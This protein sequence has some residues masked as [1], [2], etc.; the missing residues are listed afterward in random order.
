MMPLF[1][2]NLLSFGNQTLDHTPNLLPADAGGVLSFGIQPFSPSA[3]GSAPNNFFF[4]LI[5]SIEEFDAQVFPNVNYLPNTSAV[6]NPIGGQDPLTGIDLREMRSAGNLLLGKPADVPAVRE[7][8]FVD[9]AVE[10]YQSLVAGIQPGA[11][12]VIL[13]AN[14]NGTDQI[15][16][17]LAHRADISALHI[18]SHGEPGSLRLGNST[19]NLAGIAETQ[20]WANALNPDA[21]IL[22][23]G[24]DVASGTQ[25][26]AF[27]EKLGELTGADVAAS[28]DKT[29]SAIEGGDWLLEYGAGSI[30]TDLAFNEPA[31][32]AYDSVFAIIDSI[33]QSTFAADATF[34]GTL[35]GGLS[36][37][38]Y[39][40]A[41]NQYY[42]IADARNN[43]TGPVRFYTFN[44]NVSS[45]TLAAGGATATG[46]TLLGNPTAFA[47][48]TSDTEGIALAPGG[49]TA[50]IASEGVFSGTT[51]TAQPFINQFNIATGVQTSALPVPSKFTATA[52]TSGIVS[53]AAFESLSISPTG[54]FLF[55]ATEN[56]LKQ[57]GAVPT[58]S[59]GTPSRILTYN[60]GTSTAGAEYLYNTDA[61]NGISEILALDN[62][63][64]LVL[65]RSMNPAAQT[66]SLRLY[67]VSLTGAT[68]ISG[69]NALTGSPTAAQKTLVADFQTTAGFP[70]N[71]FEGMTLGPTLPSGKRSLI[72]ISDNNYGAGFLQL[73]TQVAAFSVNSA[74]VLDN[75]GNPT[76]TTI[77]EDPI[78][79]TGT[80]VST[81]IGSSITDLDSADPEGIAVTGLDTTNGIWQYSTDGTTWT[82]LGTPSESAAMLLTAD[83]NTRIRFSPN[84]NYNGVAGNITFRAWDGT[85]GTNGTTAN[86]TTLG[87]GGL[88]SF[89]TATETASITV[90]AVN[91]APVLTVPGAQTINQ[92]TNSAIAGISLSDID[93]GTGNLQ[94]TLS[95]T[96]GTLTFGT[97]TSLTFSTG[98][99][100]AD[101]SMTFTGSLTNI[102]SALANLTYQGNA[103]Y[104]GID[105]INL[106]V[107]DLG[108]TGTGGALTA[109]NSIA[110]N[111]TA[112]PY[113]AGSVLINE[114]V[115]DPQRDWSS[116]NFNG[117]V[118]A[119]AI[120][121]GTDEWVELYIRQAGLDLTNWT[122]ELLDGTNVFGSLSNNG[123]FQFSNYISAGGGSFTN[124][125]AGD[126]LVLGDVIGTGAMNDNITLVIKDHTGT[127]IDQVIVG[128][129]GAPS[130]VATGVTNEAVARVPNGNDAIDFRKQAATLGT[131][132]NIGQLALAEH[133][134]AQVSDQFAAPTSLVPAGT[135]LHRFR[136][137]ATNEPINISNL[138]FT[139]SQT[140][141]ANTDF[142]GLRLVQDANNN[143]VDDAGD[144][145]VGTVESPVNI[146]DGLTFSNITAPVGTSNYLLSTGVNNLLAGDRLTFN[147]TTANI[148]AAGN[149]SLLPL[150]TTGTVSGTVH[151]VDVPPL[152]VVINE[153][154]WM[155]TQAAATDEWIELY[156][157][158]NNAIDL[159]GWTLQ[160][161]GGGTLNYTIQN[162]VIAAGGY[163]L[164]ER[165]ANTTVSN[166]AA[167]AIFTGGINNT[168][169]ISLVL[170]ES[171]GNTIDTANGNGGAWPAGSNTAATVRFTMERI[172]PTSADIDG[173]WLTNTGLIQNGLDAGNNAIHGTPRAQNSVYAI[174]EVV[175][176]ES[177]GNTNIAEGGVTDTYTVVLKTPVTAPVTINLGTA[178]GQTSVSNPFLTFDINNWNI[179]QTVTVSAVD[180]TTLEGN[181][182]GTINHVASSS[183]SRYNG[184]TIASVNAN[185]TDNESTPP[186][187]NF[188][189]G[190]LNYTENSGSVLVDAGATVT[191]P[192]SPDFNGG[193]LTVQFASATGLAEDSLS[194][195]NQGTGAGQISIVGNVVSYGGVAIAT[196]SGGTNG[197]TP[198]VINFNSN[199]NITS[200][201]ALLQNITYQNSSE[202]PSTASRTLQFQMT[203]GD[204]G[205]GLP[206]NKAINLTAVN[207]AP[208]ISAIAPQTTNEDTTT[209]PITFT[210]GDIET[211]A[212]A[213][214][215]T[216]ISSN[217]TLIPDANIAFGGS[218]NNRT[219]T[220]TPA[221]NQN[222]NATITINVN[223]GIAINSTSFNLTV[224]AVNDA[225]V[226]A[227]N[228]GL[229]LTEGTSG[230]INTGT[231]QV[232]DSDTAPAQLIYTVSNSPTNGTLFLNNV[233]TTSFTQDDISNNRIT[234]L[235]S[236]N[237]TASDSFTFTVSDGTNTVG[238]STFNLTINAVNDAPVL[239]TN[240]GLTLTEGSSTTLS[241]G[242]LQVTDV[243]TAPAQL[244][245]SVTNSPTNGTL[246][247]NNVATTSFTQDDINN[248]RITYL[249]SG[250]ETS[251]DSFIFTVSDGT[252]TLGASTFNFVINAVNDAPVLATNAGLTL[253]EGTS[254]VINTGTLQVTD[255]DTA[256]AQLIYTVTNSPTNGSLFLN[257]VATTSFTQDDIDNN[258]ITYL[259][260]GNETASD[261]FTFTVSDGTNTVGASTFNLT[262]NAVNDAPVL[263]TNAGLTLTEGGSANVSSG[264][265]QVTDVDTAPAQLI[266]SVTNSPINGTL[267]LNNVATTSFTQD[268]INNNRVTYLHSGS[269]TSTDSFIFT[270]SDGTN[271]V[272]A[273]TFNFVINAVNDVP[274]LATNAGLTLN[275]GTSGIINTGTLQVTDSDT[276]PAQ[277][278]YSVT[279]SPTNGTLF[280]NNV[281]TTSFTQDDIN[282]NRITYLH[283][284]NET[285]SDSFTF[286][287]SDGT[288]TLSAS[289]FNFTINA[290][291]DV[292][293][294]STN[295]GLTLNEGTSANVSSGVLQVTDVDTAPAQLIYSVTNS[296]TNGTL[297]LNGVATTSFTQDDINN[298]RVTYLH[299]GS[300]TTTDSFTFTVSDGANTLNAATF[301]INITPVNDTPAA[302]NDS[303]IAT[304]DTPLTVTLANSVLTN[305]TDAENNSLTAPLVTNPNNGTVVFNANGTFT[306]TPNANFAGTDSF[307]YQASDGTA[308]SNIAT[309][310]LT[311]NPVNDA[312]VAV[313]DSYSTNKNLPLTIAA[314]TGILANDSDVENNPLTAVLITETNNGTLSL[315]S[316]GSFTYTPN[317]DFIG[318]DSFTYQVNDG[319]LN[320]NAVTVSITVNEA[321]AVPVLAR[322]AGLTLNEGADVILTSGLLQTTDAD[323]LPTQ[324]IY[325]VTASP[326][327][328]TL[329]LNGVVTTSFTQDDID[330]NRITYT[331][332]GGETT[333]DSFTFTVSDG[334]GGSINSTTFN[335]TVNPVNDAPVLASNA[336]ITL[337]EAGSFTLTNS[338][339]NV[340]DAENNQLTYTLT[341]LPI[342]GALNLNGVALKIGDI[343]TQ[344]DI[345]NSLL[346]YTHNGSETTSDSFNFTVS[347][348]AGGSL[349]NTFNITIN[350]V[351][352]APAANNDSLTLNEN[353][354]ATT[355]NVLANDTDADGDPL[356]IA[357]FTQPS[358]GILLSNGDGTFSYTPNSNFAGS[359]SF[360]YNISDG[361][362]GIDTGI[363]TLTINP[364]PT[365]TPEPTPTPIPTPEP[366]P[367]PTPIPTPIPTPEPTP[368]PTPT[369]EPTPTPIPTPE[370]TPTPIPTPEPTPTPIPTPEPTPI[371]TPI[372][373][374]EPTPTPIPTPIPTP[375]PT[376]IPTPSPEPAP[377]PTPIPIPSE[378]PLPNNQPGTTPNAGSGA[379][380]FENFF[381]YFA[382]RQ[383]DFINLFFDENYYLA[384]N[385]DVAEAVAKGVY[386]TGFEHF[387]DFGLFEGRNPS[388]LFDNQ[389]YVSANADVAE[390]IAAGVY[391][392]GFEHF[393]QH[394]LF[395]ERDLKLLLF[396]EAYYRT[397]NLDVAEAIE[398]GV[399]DSGYEH[400]IKH[401]QFEGR[402]PSILFNESYYLAQNPEVAAAVAAGTYRS[403]FEHFIQVGLFAGLNPSALFDNQAY[404]TQNPEVAAAVAAGTYHSGFEH[405]L[406][407]GLFEGSSPQILLSKQ[408]FAFESM[409][410][411]LST[412]GRGAVALF[413]DENVYLAENPDVREAIANGDFNT[414]LEHFLKFAPPQ[415]RGLISL[416]FNEET[417]LAENP[418]VA[419]AVAQGSYVSGLEHFLQFG[420]FEGRDSRFLLFD[421]R[422]YLANNPDV[423]EAVDKGVYRSGF[424]HYERYGQAEGRNPSNL[425]DE[426]FYLAENADVAE[427]VAAGI[428]RSGFEHFVEH[429]L[430]EGRNPSA[431]FD[432]R[433]YLAENPDVAEAVAAGEYRSGFEQFLKVGL[434]AG[435]DSQFLQFNEAAYL[436]ANAD[437]A[438]AVAAGVYSNGFEHFKRFGRFE[439]RAGLIG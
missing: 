412:A 20:Q 33:G 103:N 417:Y 317:A 342:N 238:A 407:I 421:E 419:Y 43:G 430:F 162:G 117:V 97:L 409:T 291:N 222:G 340:T 143:G 354:P 76:L 313:N 325:T 395:E 243:D 356:T 381:Q 287:V 153:V 293:V 70:I 42:V 44:I 128:G 274:V 422:F 125:A 432:S 258:R 232:T 324:L 260:S 49:A 262:I 168:G 423:Q 239:S 81:L 26:E 219:V 132:N 122:I 416:F 307:T 425:F 35:I 193:V 347:D 279:N 138:T 353:A 366:T 251:T 375:E 384:N 378:S 361:K 7:I 106:S 241:S 382:T 120:T 327:N 285:A 346:S 330:N 349:S 48:N 155:G 299:N 264:V 301:A 237:E 247:L 160:S 83:A 328:G 19:L 437:V 101:G 11:E 368:I 254:G 296:P 345:N 185:I 255:S 141:I 294:L 212:D 344:T 433:R 174:P 333:P 397:M 51:P 315:D 105:N 29:G 59:T 227:T 379:Y 405:F 364:I 183:D 223:D 102:N 230:I 289:T 276:A 246:F 371:P 13:D 319:L 414:G 363:V 41:N 394:G 300:E 166:I 335:I 96:N 390:A 169:G 303:Y 320:S 348:G 109:S 69:L 403:A 39:N 292:P 146:A 201:S 178:F 176:T 65:E 415:G 200:V 216:A 10:D 136:L 271:T 305:D 253:N 113:A 231:L 209:T 277:L 393:I 404:L 186:T 31:R 79:N 336:G 385:P 360:T 263:S 77:N 5:E 21:D 126:Y 357:S 427:A 235:H 156:N 386:H 85:T 372:P 197:T 124:T 331:H 387:L 269:E 228:A 57:D 401:G 402:N 89:S 322:N 339:L 369:P 221:A 376:P 189:T 15:S 304:E 25:G 115:T 104:F 27:V 398:S 236:G 280:L 439:G 180:D 195:R 114:A 278:I 30:E 273:S 206:V 233:A 413:F 157:P 17:V 182:I 275:E 410:E 267:F 151:T 184:I 261:S 50:F 158:T 91:D 249:H 37:I 220:M 108:N 9:A 268:D 139:A 133:I 177:G 434:Q 67:Q 111:V 24:C 256:P 16:E 172:D 234:Y 110:V 217:T 418:D 309:I 259:H 266:Y 311:V 154:A 82:S 203:D 248:N 92:N 188:S 173:N 343:F 215:L 191:D 112:V 28:T 214:I 290:V 98:D 204:T 286:T 396:D 302:N 179:A 164:L 145:V 194:I 140:G 116:N 308:N 306:Y 265:L 129:A 161:S 63:T 95:A 350:P 84:A 218:G 148:T 208:T 365:P 144:V 295:A 93:A 86:I 272:G 54:Q 244:I 351:N 123:A 134:S 438:A 329:L 373:T 45:G 352:V 56:A 207:D 321:N 435:R 23:Y 64:L 74:P 431:L 399:Y 389:Q 121:A 370:P 377:I 383:R 388:E 167:D 119:G 406:K 245:Y 73:A 314:G 88:A 6:A 66:G 87:T 34:G 240:A 58:A 298:N 283:S 142:T 135:V 137:T 242:V 40:S 147:L 32:S 229:T 8:I 61:G 205:I 18:V 226:L 281:A 78:I 400:F 127:I 190:P 250:S 282:N 159:T 310:T 337:L 284:A 358:N 107:S 202:N 165:T 163:F 14:R 408:M 257:G 2:E 362:G 171:A 149:T 99:G 62:T 131:S 380:Y 391:Q 130:G 420:L 213:L 46:V 36:G 68:D 170:R 392:S 341:N 224:D 312:P 210:I 225:P 90:N 150:A 71:N 152:A 192:D 94:V 270:V 1:D 198:L 196:F 211:A 187:I 52:G 38:T 374:P 334:A 297:F 338:Q 100:T 60:L 55:T 359:D 355:I 316:N 424:E 332:N 12:V 436:A 429:G 47:A 80:L 72:L 175:I 22:I 326:T 75:T 428:Y 288:N 323:N 4:S 426:K 118:G 181:H 3:V 318:N 411:Y 367:E 53:N 252:N 199:A